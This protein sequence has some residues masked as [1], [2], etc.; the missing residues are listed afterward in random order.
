MKPPSRYAPR[1]S[2]SREAF[3]NDANLGDIVRDD[4]S[5]D[6]RI[7]RIPISHL[8][9][10]SKELR[11]HS[12]KKRRKLASLL[13]RFGQ[14]L[15]ILI[16]E[17]YRLVD[18]HAVVVALKELGAI[19]VAAVVVRHRTPDEV[20]ALRLAVNRIAQDAEWNRAALCEEFAELLELG[21]DLDLTGFDAVEVDMTLEIGEPT[22]GGVEEASANDIEPAE[23]AAIVAPGDVW[24][25]GDHMIACGDAQD[26]ALLLRLLGERR[27]ATVFTD[28]P[29]NVKIAGFVS[30][31]G[32]TR[33]REF[34]MGA[35]E[36]SPA[37]FTCFLNRFLNATTPALAD[38]AI[39]YVCMDWRHMREL[40]EAGEKASLELKN[41]CVWAKSNAGMGSFYRSQHELV[42]VFKHGKGAHQNNFGL[43]QHGRSR[44]NVWAYRG[45]NTF[46][47]DRMEL[48]GVH[49]TV[50]PV[51]LIADA[52][53]DVSKRGGVV[54][55]PFLGSGSTLLA[56]EATG[57][58]C[59]GVEIDPA[60]VEVAIRRWQN[61]TGRDA[62]NATT[63]EAFDVAV[64]RA[65][66]EAAAAAGSEAKDVAAEVDN[67]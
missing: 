59:V 3:D 50:K 51:A 26:G 16:D 48:L 23:T 37:E 14:V 62:L 60:Y 45:V 47:K 44:S 2:H 5:N 54:V 24:K 33:H 31:L 53:R 40:L 32:Q 7:I 38:G 17:D 57:R 13:Q 15:P 67:G 19:D 61:K 27:A 65:R 42:F 30:G 39:L 10:Y 25:L 28:P 12:A 43:G 52:L 56:A 20:R 41:L 49:P 6:I 21:F 64:E 18:G 4:G 66:A 46:G 11:V 63:G 8:Q 35:G 55:D 9:P 22:S 36:M 34:A 1:K 58:I 29:Y